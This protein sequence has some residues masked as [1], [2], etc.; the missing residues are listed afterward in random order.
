MQRYGVYDTYTYL[1]KVREELQ[2]ARQCLDGNIHHTNRHTNSIKVR[3]KSVKDPEETFQK[4]VLENSSCPADEPYGKHIQIGDKNM[5]LIC[6]PKDTEKVYY[7]QVGDKNI[8][9]NLTHSS[10]FF[11]LLMMAKEAGQEKV[12]PLTPDGESMYHI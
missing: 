7:K 10:R 9:V 1:P 8:M 6:E 5:M 12:I 2:H 3:K 11:Q 4:E